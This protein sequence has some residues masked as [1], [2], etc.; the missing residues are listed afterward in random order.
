M[1]DFVHF[2]SKRIDFRLRFSN[3]KTLGIS[4]TP[5]MSVLVNAPLN[6]PIGKIKEKVKGKAA[7]I[8][9]KQGLFLAYF[10]RTP[11]KKYVSGETHLYLGRQNRLKVRLGRRSEVRYK[12]QVIEVI[13]QDKAKV[14]A[15]VKQWFRDRAKEKFSE[16]SRPLIEKFQVYSSVS[17]RLSVQEMPT[18]W[19]SCTS[20]GKIILNPE[21]VKAP[22][23]C[24][25]YVIIHE[26]CHLIHRNHTRR[27]VELQTKVMPDWEKWKSKL[28]RLMA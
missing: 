23:G 12:G 3:R 27:F 5:E 10:P 8:I 11:E 13:V 18:R 19:G 24:I 22:K 16:I 2:G 9:T 6:A 1:M 20:K 28:E 15:L 7:W 21:L 17:P 14:S 26:L 25:E 4:V